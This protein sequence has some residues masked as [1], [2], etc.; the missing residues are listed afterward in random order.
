[1][2]ATGFNRE[3]ACL[4]GIAGIVTVVGGG[5]IALRGR[6]GRVAIGAAGIASFGVA[7]AL[8][9]GT[10]I[11]AWVIV[12]RLTGTMERSC[13]GRWT[14]ALAATLPV[15]RI[16]GFYADERVICTMVEKLA[17]GRRFGPLAADMESHV[18]AV[19]AGALGLPFAIFCCVSDGALHLLQPAVV[20]SMRPD[21]GRR[22]RDA[23]QP[24][25]KTG[26]SRRC[27]TQHR[28]LRSRDQPLKKG[29]GAV[30]PRL[31]LPT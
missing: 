3:G 21:G 2:L 14:S 4:A 27:R 24:G 30:G 5:P 28:W 22:R 23:R 16:D 13:D 31:V 29:V 1:M 12:D 17:F 25:A 15:P 6:I 20:A 10:C 11:G 9:D 26:P 19:A 18:A 8:V 7:G